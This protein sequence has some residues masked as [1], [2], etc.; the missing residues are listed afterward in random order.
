MLL[1]I[2][3]WIENN[4]SLILLILLSAVL[5]IPSLFE[6]YWYGDEG[7][8]LVLGQG[9]RKGLILYKDIHDNKPPLLYMLA[10]IAGN[11]FYF[12][13]MLTIWFG[14]AVG[15]FYKLTQLLIPKKKVAATIATTLMIALTTLT[16]GNIANAEIFIVLPII[17]A[18]FMALKELK[19]K[20]EKKKIIRWAVMG[21]LMSVGFLLKVPAVFDMLALFLWV[22]VT[23]EMNGKN[24]FKSVWRVVSSKRLWL[25]GLGFIVPIALSIIYYYK[26]GA[27]E[28]YFRSAL[29]QNIGYLA[30]FK[31]GSHDQGLGAQTGLISRT[32]GLL[33]LLVAFFPL[34]KKGNIT[35]KGKLLI[36]WFLMA[37]FGALLPERPYPHYL[38]QPII[39]GSLLLTYFL[40]VK[41]KSL[42][43]WS[44][45]VMAIMVGFYLK[46]SFW[47]YPVVDYYRNF[48]DYITKVKT[49]EEYRN[50]FDFRVNQTYKLAD[51]LKRRTNSED[52]VFIWGDEPTIYALAN[53]LPVGRYT[54][55]YHVVDFNGYDETL[56]AFDKYQPKVVIVMKYEKRKFDQLMVRLETDYLLTETI[57]RADIYRRIKPRR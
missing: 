23:Q 50:Y 22:G 19:R 16:E 45:V 39:P 46:I 26:V 38:I 30:S 56:E 28:R 2:K 7:I 55:A 12:R 51:Y 35:N 37:L 34:A 21:L 13:L 4:E 40:F 27:G 17:M 24:I 15:F 25:M 53:R 10:A 42:R 48:Y 9:I 36:T 44:I 8:Y 1:K 31:T 3:K 29:G 57:D 6:P 33:I 47:H 20:S 11:V 52:R 41:N 32:V 14:V 5:R 54:V 49:I 18:T 43:L